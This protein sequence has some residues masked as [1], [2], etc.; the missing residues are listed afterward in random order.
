VPDARDDRR[1]L[2]RRLDRNANAITV[3]AY[4]QRVEL[5][6]AA[7]HDDDVRAVAAEKIHLLRE[8]ITI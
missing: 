4:L 1:T 8:T 2:L 7:A 3:L 6:Y 5:T